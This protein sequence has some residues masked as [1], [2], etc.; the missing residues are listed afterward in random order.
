M[1]TAPTA[2]S[3][4]LSNWLSN[5]D[6]ELIVQARH[7]RPF[8]VLGPHLRSGSGVP[9]LAIRIF[10]PLDV[11]ITVTIKGRKH[12]AFCR[13]PK[14][15]FECIISGAGL[16][17]NDPYLLELVGRDG[18]CTSIDDPYRFP[19]FISDH[20]YHLW[21]EGKLYA[22]WRSLGAHPGCCLGVNGVRFAVWAPN[23]RRMSVIGPF[24]GW[25]ERTHPMQQTQ[26]GLWSFSFQVSWQESSTNSRSFPRLVTTPS[27]RWTRLAFTQ[28]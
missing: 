28:T 25:D 11:E 5:T 7:S 23:A 15:F 24:N 12:P 2:S 20:D 16:Q 9:T 6:I 3:P 22:A 26:S 21:G 13:H 27:T 4:S 17:A 10:R 1:S 8:D 18:T 14:G 19:T